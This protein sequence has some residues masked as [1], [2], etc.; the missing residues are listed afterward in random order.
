MA[1]LPEHEAAARLPTFVAEIAR[2]KQPS[3]GEE[4][5]SSVISIDGVYCR[6]D[7]SAAGDSSRPVSHLTSSNLTGITER[8]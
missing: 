4:L 1:I 8:M 2:E 5:P 7:V 3:H 6:G